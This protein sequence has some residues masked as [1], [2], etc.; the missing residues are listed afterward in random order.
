MVVYHFGR[1]SQFARDAERFSICPGGKSKTMRGV[2]GFV[3][4]PF[5]YLKNRERSCEGCRQQNPRNSGFHL[6][7]PGVAFWRAPFVANEAI[8]TNP[9]SHRVSKSRLA[10]YSM[11][12]PLRRILSTQGAS[13]WDSLR[14]FHRS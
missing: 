7:P 2:G 10:T 14:G 1:R 12:K 4:K 9:A 3:I 11:T 5:A 8:S 13:A 6:H